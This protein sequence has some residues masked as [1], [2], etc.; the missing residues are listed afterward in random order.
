MNY[1]FIIKKCNSQSEI[2]CVEKVF[3]IVF[4][5]YLAASFFSLVMGV[6]ANTLNFVIYEQF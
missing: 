6:G 4:V 2:Y 3:L 1:H 5:K